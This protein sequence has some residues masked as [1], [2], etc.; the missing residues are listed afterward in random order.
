MYHISKPMSLME[1]ISQVNTDL[2]LI[3]TTLSR[4]TDSSF[5]VAHESLEEPRNAA[6]YEL[7][8]IPTKLA[9]VEMAKQFGYSSIVLKPSFLSEVDAEGEKNYRLGA[10]RAFVCAKSS[11]LSAFPAQTEVVGTMNKN[12]FFKKIKNRFT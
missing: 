5:Q 6:D 12:S 4:A 7:V 9:V 8:L 2:L 1:S 3:D 11:D 10:R